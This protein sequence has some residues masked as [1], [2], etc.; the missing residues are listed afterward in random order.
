MCFAK[1]PHTDML[2]RVVVREAKMLLNQ[3]FVLDNI[4][5][6]GKAESSGS[7]RQALTVTQNKRYKL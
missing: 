6:S 7:A 1:S 2:R 3:E 4:K 5:L